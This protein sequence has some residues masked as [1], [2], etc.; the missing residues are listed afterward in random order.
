MRIPTWKLP[1][2]GPQGLSRQSLQPE[3]RKALYVGYGS[4]LAYGLIIP[5]FLVYL[6]AKQNLELAINRRCVCWW[7]KANAGKKVTVQAKMMKQSEDDTET[8]KAGNYKGRGRE[9]VLVF[10]RIQAFSFKSHPVA[11]PQHRT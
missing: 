6:I 7:A 9:Q 4:A 8:A 3:V 1:G 5:S 11:L 2:S 10:V